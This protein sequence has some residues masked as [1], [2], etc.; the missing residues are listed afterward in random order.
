M[1]LSSMAT[2]LSIASY[3][4]GEIEKQRENVS[5]RSDIIAQTFSCVSKAN[6]LEKSYPTEVID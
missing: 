1:R 6:A 4:F 2:R 3:M 5:Y